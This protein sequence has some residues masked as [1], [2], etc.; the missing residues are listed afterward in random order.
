M[1]HKKIQSLALNFF[2]WVTF[3]FAIIGILIVFCTNKLSNQ[4]QL[5]CTKDNT[6][7]YYLSFEFLFAA[8]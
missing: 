6:F 8:R 4:G 3:G 7:L 1:I 2:D 5:T